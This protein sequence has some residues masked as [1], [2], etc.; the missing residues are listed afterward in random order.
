MYLFKKNLFTRG[1][2]KGL[3]APS[4]AILVEKTEEFLLV[5]QI[6][7]PAIEDAGFFR[8]EGAEGAPHV[9]HAQ[10]PCTSLLCHLSAKADNPSVVADGL[11]LSSPILEADALDELADQA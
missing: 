1:P 4:L 2:G 9:S 7:N 5:A 6:V 10:H 8:T 3:Q 11:I